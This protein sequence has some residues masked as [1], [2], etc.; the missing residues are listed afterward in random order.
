MSV[1]RRD[2][3]RMLGVT[4]AGV[5]LGLPAIHW[6]GARPAYAAE[7]SPTVHVLNRLTWGVRPEDLDRITKMGIPA[8]IDWQLHPEKI[9]DPV[10]DAFLKKEVPSL[11]MTFEEMSRYEAKKYGTIELELIFAR[12]YRAAY[13][14]RQLFE[15]VVD[16]WTDHFNIPV[17]DYAHQKAMDDRIVIRKHAL[18]RFRDMLVASAQSPAMLQYLNNDSSEKEH[19]NENY[20]REVMELHTLGV[21]GGYSE[22]DVK[23][24]ARI[25]TGWTLREGLPD[26]FYFDPDMHDDGE[27]TLLG[28]NFPAKRGV[29]EGLEALDL[30]ATHPSTAKFIS[31]KL[32]RRFISDAPPQSVVDSATAVFS[33]TDGDIRAVLAHIF[34]SPEFMAAAGQKFRRPLDF[35][36]A[37]MRTTPITFKTREAWYLGLNPLEEMGQLPFGWHPPN[38]YPDAARAWINTNGLMMR[39][40]LGLVLGLIQMGAVDGVAIELERRV[41]PAKTAAELVDNVIAL[42]LPGAKIAAADRDQLITFMSDGGG[43][44]KP[45]DAQM[46]LERMPTVLGL[47]MGSPY[48]QWR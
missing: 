38:G 3:L 17:S 2:F 1:N 25:L 45:A 23:A 41:A 44:T 29:E 30:L 22:A 5:G 13:S 33:K 47:L 28:R 15:I 46:R 36:A 4:A 14:E 6:S 34:A 32:C 11:A 19:P 27:K 37:L 43:A 10:I 16:F 40:N 48:F 18:G 42:V 21:N 9:A 20:A 7:I 24:L 26:G 31:L 35:M 8:F 12:L 39:W